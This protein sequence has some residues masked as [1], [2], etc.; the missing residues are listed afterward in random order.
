M[1]PLRLRHRISR[2]L[3]HLLSTLP[4]RFQ[5][6]PHNVFAHPLSELVWQVGM[7]RGPKSRLLKWSDRIHDV[8]VPLHEDGTGRG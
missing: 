4:E 5:W 7:S 1:T 2:R 8:T 6:T 3:P